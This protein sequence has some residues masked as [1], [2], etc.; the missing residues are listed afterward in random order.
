[1]VDFFYST[2]LLEECQLNCY[3][4]KICKSN[5]SEYS[6]LPEYHTHPGLDAAVTRLSWISPFSL[7]WDTL[8][9]IALHSWPLLV[10]PSSDTASIRVFLSS[11]V[12]WV[13]FQRKEKQKIERCSLETSIL[14]ILASF[15]ICNL[16]WT[17][18]LGLHHQIHSEVF[19][20]KWWWS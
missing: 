18:Y 14:K 9:H 5:Y 15:R 12:G 13:P 6:C 2:L 7:E 16:L 4:L 8:K 1:M 17:K 20:R 19:T 10:I 11:L 3:P